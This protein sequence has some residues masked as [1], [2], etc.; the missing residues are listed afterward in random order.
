MHKDEVKRVIESLLFVHQ[1]P[2]TLDNIVKLIGDQ[3]GKKVIKEAV[4]ELVAE[5][6]GM[7]RSFLLAEV[8]EG[9]QFRTK[10]AYAPW[11]RNLRKV[12]PAKL[13]QSALETL[14]IVVYRQP[15][16]RAEIEHIRGVDSGWVLNSLLEKGLIKILGR[17][18]VAGRPLV[19]GSSRRF[20]EVFG[21]RNLSGL[22]TLQELDALRGKEGVELQEGEVKGE[23]Q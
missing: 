14:A 19:Y 4:G 13:S 6:Q 2:L 17:K 7:G 10:A 5:Y 18:E 1:H 12:K 15:I 3:A 9:Y 20:L 22:P 23:E 21:L 8:D 11:I 16:V